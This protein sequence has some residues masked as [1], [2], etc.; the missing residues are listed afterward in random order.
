MLLWPCQT[1]HDVAHEDRIAGRVS[2]DE[3]LALVRELAALGP[4]APGM[5]SGDRAARLV[6]SRLRAL[7]L[8]VEVVEDPP[9]PGYEPISWRVD[10]EGMRLESAWPWQGSPAVPEPVTAP[11]R[12]AAGKGQGRAVLFA[13]GDLEG[14]YDDLAAAGAVALLTDHPA[15]PERF[16]D[17][18]PIRDLRRFAG[19]NP[20]IPVFGLSYK[21]GRR[22]RKAI[23]DGAAARVTVSLDARTAQGRPLT[24]LATL[25]GRGAGARDEILICA[26]GDADG[27]GPGADD[28]ASGVAVLVEAA[29]ALAWADA[30]NLL[31]DDRPAV[32]FAVWGAEYH[33]SRH[34]VSSRAERLKRLRA[35]LNVDQAGTGA[36]RDAIYFEGND[37]PWNEPLLKVLSG[38]ARDRAGREGSWT[39]W[40]TSPAMG[41]TD[42][43]SF[44]PRQYHGDGLTSERIPSITVFTSA[45][46]SSRRLAQAPGWRSPDWPEEPEIFID[47]SAYY[48]SSGDTPANTTDAEPWNIERCARAVALGV[49]RFMSV[50][51]D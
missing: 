33:S 1:G 40:T 46:D 23:E 15:D 37:I 35:V 30:E 38:L 47:Y 44:L 31:P 34:F 5:P 21:D 27:G 24:V 43:Y 9:G 49:R 48:H 2:R 41:D 51:P 25:A 6:A 45:W 7:G 11:L 50:A 39:H 8:E 4:R 19:A 32:T 29:R 36:R 10:L 22:V 42:A 28:N 16:I 17:W 14:S 12:A 13:P 3:A 18:A 20:P 26:H